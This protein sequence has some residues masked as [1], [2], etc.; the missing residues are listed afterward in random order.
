MK[1]LDELLVGLTGDYR[2]DYEKK[3]KSGDYIYGKKDKRIGDA[4]TIIVDG[5][6]A[7]HFGYRCNCPGCPYAVYDIDRNEACYGGMYYV[8]INEGHND[9]SEF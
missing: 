4:D 9:D 5:V 3:F 1:N 6:G 8:C 2:K 7:G